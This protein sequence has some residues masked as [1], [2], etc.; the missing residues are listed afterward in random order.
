MVENMVDPLQTFGSDSSGGSGGKKSRRQRREDK[1]FIT[2][3]NNGKKSRFPITIFG[4]RKKAD[5]NVPSAAHPSV[6]QKQKYMDQQFD[7]DMS[8]FT[9]GLAGVIEGPD[10]QIAQYKL[11]LAYLDGIHQTIL[12]GLNLDILR[13]VISA[14]PAMEKWLMENAFNIT[15]SQGNKVS[16]A[17]LKLYDGSQIVGALNPY[18]EKGKEGGIFPMGRLDVIPLNSRIYMSLSSKGGFYYRS[19]DYL[20]PIT[21]LTEA[22]FLE[23]IQQIKSTQFIQL[24]KSDIIAFNEQMKNI[25]VGAT[26]NPV[27]I[28]KGNALRT[29]EDG[30]MPMVPGVPGRD[31]NNGQNSKQDNNKERVKSNNII[32]PYNDDTFNAA[33]IVK[34]EGSTYAT[35]I[36]RLSMRGVQPDA[37][38]AVLSYLYPFSLA[39]G[40][41]V[42]SVVNVLNNPRPTADDKRWIDDALSFVSSYGNTNMQNKYIETFIKAFMMAENIPIGS[43]AIPT[44]P[45]D[46]YAKVIQSQDPQYAIYRTDFQRF[47]TPTT[48]DG[49]KYVS[50]YF[51]AASAGGIG[52]GGGG[53]LGSSRGFETTQNSGL[54]SGSNDYWSGRTVLNAGST[55]SGVNQMPPRG[56]PTQTTPPP[57]TGSTLPPRGG[58][59][60]SDEQDPVQ[61]VRAAMGMSRSTGMWDYSSNN[62]K[63]T[64]PIKND[65]SS[66]T[67]ESTLPP[68]DSGS[69]LPPRGDKASTESTLPPKDSGSTLP[70]R[71]GESTKPPPRSDFGSGSGSG[72]ASSLKHVAGT[73]MGNID[74][75]D[76]GPQRDFLAAYIH[77]ANDTRIKD[78]LDTLADELSRGSSRG[79]SNTEAERFISQYLTTG[80]FGG[81]GVTDAVAKSAVEAFKDTLKPDGSDRDAYG[82]D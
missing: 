48:A 45:Q 68:R 57:N 4:K 73:V 39:E 35:L 34:D 44:D 11:A 33:K 50:S 53:G 75:G 31:G 76:Y 28:A 80:E 6:L 65:H 42:M 24:V 64:E 55:G 60:G 1:K 54:N 67:T 51:K 74:S 9:V 17:N 2:K 22:G 61:K 41:P 8:K 23:V 16:I 40:V 32:H 13:D 72:T 81:F 29:K 46:F 49:Y 62:R 15:D 14:S 36:G 37:M 70:P 47:M 79:V 78:A 18:V 63:T 43:N 19:G 71:D 66:T 25:D 5:A 38:V 30:G 26:P 7:Q 52:S 56:G 82:F 10:G 27:N 3:D 21:Q 12:Q 69:T 20:I 59:P 77:N 58:P